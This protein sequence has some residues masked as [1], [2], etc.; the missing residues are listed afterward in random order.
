MVSKSFISQ[1]EPGSG[2]PV[3]CMSRMKE[4]EELKCPHVHK[5]VRLQYHAVS[6]NDVTVIYD[7]IYSVKISIY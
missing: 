7:V 6:C 2:I 3:F 4:V 1:V 5:D